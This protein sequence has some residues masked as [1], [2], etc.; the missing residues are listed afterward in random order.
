MNDESAER[1]TV[2]ECI[3]HVDPTQSSHLAE[4]NSDLITSTSRPVHHNDTHVDNVTLWQ[5]LWPLLYITLVQI[6]LLHG[7]ILVGKYI[8]SC[9][10]QSDPGNR[11][12]IIPLFADS[13]RSSA[14]SFFVLLCIEHA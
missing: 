12:M 11:K 4:A 1:L 14:G 10:A 5:H 7:N 9:R 8:L 3:A 2:T 6:F 13:Y